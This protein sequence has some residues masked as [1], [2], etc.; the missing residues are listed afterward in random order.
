MRAAAHGGER[1]ENLLLLGQQRLDLF[2]RI[3]ASR[4]IERFADNPNDG[5]VAGG[6]ALGRLE[7]AE[8]QFRRPI[9]AVGCGESKSL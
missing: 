5:L 4:K 9:P 7:C 6:N 1:L 2:G 3:R 8:A